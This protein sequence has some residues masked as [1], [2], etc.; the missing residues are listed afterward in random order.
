M[1][2]SRKVEPS[3]IEREMQESRNKEEFTGKVEAITIK[4]IVENAK[5]NSR[6]GERYLSILILCMYI[7][8]HGKECVM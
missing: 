4:Q 8:H 1:C 3:V 7:F 5:V 6:F 2:Y